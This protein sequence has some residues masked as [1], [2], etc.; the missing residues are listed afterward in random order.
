MTARLHAS[1]LAALSLLLISSI[2]AAQEAPPSYPNHRDLMVWRDAQGA[3]H[4]VKTPADWQV[5]R[6]HILL[7]MQQ[8]MGPLPKRDNLP[9]LDVKILAD[10]KQDDV[11]RLSIS[12]AVEQSDDR[13]TA[14]LFL[15][16][17][18]KPDERRPGIVALH[19]TGPLG[20][21]IAAGLG[22]KPNRGYALELAQRG[23]VVISP[24]YPSFGDLKD[25]N[26]A[27]DPHVSGTMKGIL[28]HMRAVD[29]LVA[30]DDVDPA[31]LGV[32]GHSLGGHNSMFVAVFD[33]RLKAIVSSCGW[34][35]FHDYYG[36]K[37]AGWTSDRYM[38]KIRDDYGLDAGRI[39]FDWYE[40]VAALAPR[41]FFS[42][43]PLHDANFD[44][45]GVRKAIPRAQQ[46]YDLLGAS[47]QL[48]VRYPDSEHDFPTP[49]REESYAFIDRALKHQPARHLKSE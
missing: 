34:C 4:P 46:V 15:P 12:F 29:V 49:T 2:A 33:P 38:P 35:P 36:G 26:F 10:E 30:R 32:I 17:D 20:K 25:Y 45:A 44:V 14:Y 48:Q 28:N 22:P 6:Q 43:S 5:R 42:C 16:P 3:E 7:G 19:P 9:P 40:V 24:D 11:R 21:G 23:Y 27:Q 37:V 47:D 39:P 1:R 8:A 41:A 13:C 18:A 31:R